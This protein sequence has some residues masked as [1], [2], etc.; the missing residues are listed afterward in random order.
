[1]DRLEQWAEH[2]I[3]TGNKRKLFIIMQAI[4]IIL[5]LKQ[6]GLDELSQR[7][8]DD[9]REIAK[10]ILQP[11][12]STQL[13]KFR[14]NLEQQSLPIKELVVKDSK[15]NL[16][17]RVDVFE[18]YFN[19]ANNLLYDFLN[20]NPTTGN[21]CLAL[22]FYVYSQKQALNSFL[23]SIHQFCN[24]NELFMDVRPK[25]GM[26]EKEKRKEAQPEVKK[27]LSKKKKKRDVS[28]QKKSPHR[29]QKKS[30]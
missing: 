29:S 26:V 3:E 23:Y 28:V 13:Q 5:E 18:A 17:Q 25:K 22:D 2:Q 27:S 6:L 30:L 11:I 12:D 7:G 24:K 10:E 9:L 1:M 20:T 8:L 15:E 16:K 4:P 21:Q 19:S 14:N